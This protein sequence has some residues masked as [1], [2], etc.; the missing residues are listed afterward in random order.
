MERCVQFMIACCCLLT[1]VSCGS[2]HHS[3][4]LALLTAGSLI[5]D[6]PDSALLLLDE[7]AA[8]A[9]TW[10]KE[11]RMQYY[12]LRN[13]AEDKCHNLHD[14][15][16]VMQEAV[17][18][19]DKHGSSQERALAWF[20]LGRVYDK[21]QLTGDAI[22]AYNHSQATD[23][24][25]TDSA[26][27]S[28]RA[29]AANQIGQVNMYQDL[30]RQSQPHFRKAIQLGELAGD[31]VVQIYAIRNLARSHVA[32]E[33]YE[34]GVAMFKKATQMALDCDDVESFQ[35]I[36]VE[37]S[38][39]Y[40]NLDDLPRMKASL[41]A[42]HSLGT[43]DSCILT[44]QY[45][46]Y[47]LAT[48]NLDSAA[49]LFRRGLDADNPYVQRDAMLNSADILA[50]RQQ[51]REAFELLGRSIAKDDSL[52]AVEKGQHA[53][54]IAT[55]NKKLENERRQDAMLRRQDLIIIIL[56]LFL[57][58]LML[59]A[60]F[61]IKHKN[62]LNRL[63]REKADKLMLELR[64][65]QQQPRPSRVQG[66]REFSE[67]TLYTN[68]HDPRFVPRLA[69][70]NA[71]EDALNTTYDGCIEKVRQLNGKLKDKEIM[72]CMLEKAKVPNKLICA[73]L[74]MEPNALSM[75]RSRLYYKLFKRKGTADLFHEF[76][77]TL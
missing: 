25:S 54:L 30:Y 64:E 44:N 53:N 35:T 60:Y 1:I 57:F 48:G 24:L 18:Y 41:D 28:I 62:L 50:E 58:G 5:S 56:S 42:C 39:T 37:L 32:L 15:D 27:L 67:T 12:L 68:F 36:Q 34:Q 6:H 10:P 55:L 76:I 75:M 45:A 19:F 23:T 63:Q 16:S 38:D 59:F 72:L 70:Y 8:D 74:G 31:T 65:A 4:P 14:N 43:T 77:S 52:T 17:R 73:F 66:A 7:I 33:Q 26:V 40:L 9:E 20:E 51:Y 13:R 21:M 69:D 71:L 47:Y 22:N 3:Q 46:N 29:R 61:T 49:L 2:N 11:D